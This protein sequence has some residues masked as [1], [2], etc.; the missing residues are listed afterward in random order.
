MRLILERTINSGCFSFSRRLR[1]SAKPITAAGRRC[2]RRRELTAECGG[3][4]HPFL[5]GF[6]L[7]GVH[8]THLRQKLEADPHTPQF[9]K[10]DSGVGYRLTVE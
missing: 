2:A 9:L 10:T 3:G 5:H 7:G 6:G 8:V 4:P 1:L